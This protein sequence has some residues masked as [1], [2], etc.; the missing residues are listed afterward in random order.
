MAEE[1][2]V[3]V[4]PCTYEEDQGGECTVPAGSRVVLALGWG[5]KNRGLVKNFLNAQTTTISLDG[6]API[7]VSDSYSAIEPRPDQ[8]DFVTRIRHNT[9]VT[10]SA[11][12]S[13]QADG[14]V[15]VSHVAFDGFFD[16]TTHRP[17]LFRPGEPLTFSCRITAS[18]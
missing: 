4:F 14:L 5:A 3:E 2:I 8:G 6:A 16:E 9:G 12:E 10:L 1:I 18:A 15:A 11:G 17:F 13:L 7:D